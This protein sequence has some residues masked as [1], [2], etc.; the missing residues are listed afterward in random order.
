MN[1]SVTLKKIL[2]LIL[3]G[4]FPL[5]I[6][7]EDY[8]VCVGSYRY[9]KNAFAC[10]DFLAKKE[11]VT[12]VAEFELDSKLLFRVLIKEPFKTV[13]QASKYVK[14]LSKNSTVK[15]LK[16]SGIWILG[17]KELVLAERD[18][19]N[20][21]ATIDININ[22]QIEQK[23]KATLMQYVPLKK[24][25]PPV[26]EKPEES[27]PE[28]ETETEAPE[29]GQEQNAPDVALAVEE[30]SITEE[31]A[32][33]KPTAE[34]VAPSQENTAPIIEEPSLQEEPV[35][36]EPA[37][38][39]ELEP[40]SAL[41]E[42]EPLEELPD[43]IPVLEEE[44]EEPALEEEPAAIIEEPA[45]DTEPEVPVQPAEIEPPVIE[46]E[47]PI[48]PPEPVQSVKV[49]APEVRE[50]PVSNMPPEP[51]A[52]VATPTPVEKAPTPSMEEHT[53]AVSQ[54]IQTF[55]NVPLGTDV[56]EADIDYDAVIR[57]K[58]MALY[59]GGVVALPGDG[60]KVLKYAAGG[61]LGLEYTFPEFYL[62]PDSVDW[63]FSTRVEYS[64][65]FPSDNAE[66]ES[67]SAAYAVFGLWS[68]IPFTALG[69]WFAMQPE[70][71]Y[72]LAGEKAAP[73]NS[74]SKNDGIDFCHTMRVSVGFRW[75]PRAFPLL[76]VEASPFYSFVLHS[77]NQTLNQI[78][79]RV[80]F[81][82]HFG[83]VYLY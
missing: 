58:G 15:E 35:A 48:E 83:R 4:I 41:P 55:K 39:K 29:S 62:I 63:G 40:A 76:E 21:D 34:T 17:I 22:V 6:F 54:E 57:Y 69:T 25:E 71:A 80:G 67:A 72:G 18:P 47:P 32:P 65:E 70:I 28:S 68:R 52:P 30:P 50:P 23:S 74:G 1:G 12:C 75:I 10:S 26:I 2:L 27:V 43:D 14:K 53:P 78:G 37:A 36:S 49:P 13:S 9:K 51:P 81:V 82:F 3:F 8:F 60:S 44:S 77:D 46:P 16:I 38:I 73:E 31:S 59:T 66:F 56:L 61:V 11:I 19:V 7:A 45:P 64:L 5:L 33:Y 20:Y 24:E 79:A 42:P